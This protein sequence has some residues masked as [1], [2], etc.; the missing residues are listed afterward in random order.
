MRGVFNGIG[1]LLSRYDETGHFQ[2]F[3]VGDAIQMLNVMEQWIQ[4]LEP[5]ATELEELWMKKFLAGDLVNCRPED[6]G[7]DETH[8]K[9]LRISINDAFWR[10]VVRCFSSEEKTIEIV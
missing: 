4:E 7:K 3:P 9:E 2:A 5:V 1:V 8:E 10:L 6:F